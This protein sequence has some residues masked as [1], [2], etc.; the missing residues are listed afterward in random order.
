MGHMEAERIRTA[1]LGDWIV[2]ISQKKVPPGPMP[3]AAL[4]C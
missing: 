1:G 4:C 3:H 2:E